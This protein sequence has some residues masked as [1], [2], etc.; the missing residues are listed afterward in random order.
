MSIISTIKLLDNLCDHPTVFCVSNSY[1]QKPDV[2]YLDFFFHD[3][4][5]LF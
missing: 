2:D 4:A 3:N 1:L 5:Q